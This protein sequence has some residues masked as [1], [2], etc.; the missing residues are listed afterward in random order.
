MIIANSVLCALLAIYHLISHSW[1]TVNYYSFKIFQCFW[2]T[3]ITQLL[4]HDQLA[5]WKIP[6]IYSPVPLIWWCV[7]L[8]T[9]LIDGILY[10]PR[11]KAAWTKWTKKWLSRL[12]ED[13]KAEFL[14][15]TERNKYKFKHEC[16]KYLFL[17]SICQRKQY[18]VYIL[19]LCRDIGQSF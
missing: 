5:L 10:L 9:R 19:K 8:E 1:I 6:A 12:S 14:T 7:Y 2:L 18:S 3:L 16:Y 15:K 4:L 11:K 17:R 13:E